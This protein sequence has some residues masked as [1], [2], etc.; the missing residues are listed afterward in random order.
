MVSMRFSKNR[1]YLT[2]MDWIVQAF[3]YMNRAATGAGNMFQIVME[4]DGAPAEGEARDFLD[5]LVGKFPVLNGRTRRD[6]RLAP[7][8]KMPSRGQAIALALNVH[9]VEEERDALRLLEGAA[10]TPFGSK[11]EHLAFHIV[12]SPDRSYAAVTFDHCLFDARGAEA[13]LSVLQEEWEKRGACSWGSPI[14]EPVHLNQWRRKF[15]A[16]R[17]VNRAFLWL[18]EDAPPRVLPLAP[19]VSRQGFEFRVLSFSEQQTRKIMESA[20][21][22]AGYLMAMPYTLALTVQVL[23]GIFASRGVGEGDYVVP[24]TMDTRPRSEVAED[25]FFNRVSFLLF[26]I[27]AREVDDFSVLVESIKQQM[28]EQAKAGLA[29]DIWEASFLMRIAPLPILSYLMRVHLKGEI[30]SFCFSYLGDTGQMPARFMGR[31]VHRSYHM[32]RVPIP[33]G[34]G[35]FFQQSQGRL[36]VYLSYARGLLSG[37][38]VKAIAD[39]LESRLGG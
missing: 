10:N 1:H 15:E 14:P 7:Y 18:A 12:C 38:E 36:N 17:R 6:Y 4:M 31:E 22:E 11:R 29:R 34:L 37:D 2:G 20:D 5:G 16:G 30:A 32:T 27:R 19:A 39:G 28:Y 21:N 13:F 23:H 26:R 8:W 35:V 3:D 24:V 33:P 9:H 25:V